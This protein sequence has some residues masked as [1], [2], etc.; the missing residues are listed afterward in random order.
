MS[1]LS[2]RN[3]FPTSKL[4]DDATYALGLAY[5]QKEDY[6]ASKETF[7]KFLDEF[8]DSNLRSQSMYLLGT[9][10][11]NLGKFSEAIEIFKNIAKLFS[12]D[13]ELVQKAEYEIADCYYQ[14]GDEKKAMERFK[15]LRAKYPDSKLTAEVMWWLGDY[16]YRHSDLDLARRYFGSLIQDFP[17]SDLVASCYYAIGSTYTE[18]ANYQEAVN[19]FNKVI[20]LGRSDISGQAA[21][22]IADIYLKQAKYD[23]AAST[24]KEVMEKYPNL[25]SLIYPKI[26]QAYLEANDYARAVDFYRKSLEVVPVKQ[27]ADIQF[28]LAEVE[29]AQGKA[30]EAI[31]EYLKV[32][33]LYAQESHLCVKALLRVAAIYENKENFEEALNIYRRVLSMDVEEAKF[34]QERIDWINGHDKK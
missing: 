21:V 14:M 13:T 24:Y 7:E 20:D 33:Y 18:E 9:S 16:Y 17:K 5:F 32:S 30:D 25:S 6:N 26:A 11:Y 10:F 28:K 8:K 15:T 31:E 2:V 4:R 19:N 34:A 1:F 12:Q 23:L 27:M 29:E 3:N 22:A